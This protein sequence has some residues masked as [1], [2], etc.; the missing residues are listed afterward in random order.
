MTNS[1]FV[2]EVLDKILPQ[3]PQQNLDAFIGEQLAALSAN[4]ANAATSPSVN[5]S[6]PR[7]RAAY[8]FQ[9]VAAHSRYL[10]RILHFAAAASGGRLFNGDVINVACLGGGP[11]TDALGVLK[12]LRESHTEPMPQSVQCCVFDR[13]PT[14]NENWGVIAQHAGPPL[15]PYFQPLDVT[16]P[17]PNAVVQQLASVQLITISYL[18]SEVQ[19]LNHNGIVAQAV[20]T[21]FNAAASGALMVYVDNSGAHTA[22]FDS[23][24]APMGWTTICSWDWTPDAAQWGSFS[25]DLTPLD[26]YKARFNRSYKIASKLSYRVYRKP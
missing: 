4:Y 6:D 3:L 10:A 17:L 15:S 23:I 24:V 14:W 1:L 13:E 5:F 2:K 25:E 19:K 9:Y 16:Q 7:L 20:Q 8:V 18:I 11:G 21:V 12:Y 22:F 26:G